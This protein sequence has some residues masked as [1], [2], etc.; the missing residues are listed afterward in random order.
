VAWHDPCYL[1]RHNGVY[2]SPRNLLNILGNSVVELPRNRENSFCCGAGGAQFWKEEEEGTERISENRYREAEERLKG[3]DDHVLAV[4]CP[5]CK[6]MLEST[7]GR[8]PE[9]LAVRDVA[10]LLLEGVQRKAGAAAALALPTAA[11]EKPQTE[12]LS[13][14]P[15]TA[16]RAP[17]VSDA[18]T[19]APGPPMRRM[20]WTPK[21]AK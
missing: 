21:Q 8:N 3:A 15:E 7:P 17:A 19:A 5:F 13:H 20:P 9:S 6:S 10:E 18:G 1:G 4:G 16:P 12:A 2:D 11:S 14:A